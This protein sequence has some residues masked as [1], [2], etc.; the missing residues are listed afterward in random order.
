M[1]T[2]DYLC[3][4]NNH[5]VEVNHKMAE[6]VATWGELCRRAGIAQG[7]TPA[8]AKVVRLITGGN[9]IHAGSLGS[10]RERPCDTGPC[11]TPTGCGGGMCGF[12]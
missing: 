12:G 8:A 2:Y 9:V 11:G 3:P 1:P 10:K 5:V 7:V 6:K 4:A